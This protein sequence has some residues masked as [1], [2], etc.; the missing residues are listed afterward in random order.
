MRMFRIVLCALALT[1]CATLPLTDPVVKSDWD[2]TMVNA[3][4]NVDAGNYFAAQRLVDE[5]ARIH[6]DT[7][8]AREIGFWK[9]VFTLDPANEQGS[10]AGGIA[11]L[12]QYLAS[13]DSSARYR[14]E[15]LVLRRTA[16]VAQ[17]VSAAA[18]TTPSDTTAKDTVGVTTTTRSRDEE[19]VAL[20]DQLARTKDE[21][22]KVSAELDRIKKRLANPSN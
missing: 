13:S 11:G 19:I 17:G 9:A 16:A 22:A 20:K 8:E 6:P 10:L 21:L 7:P 15:A 1:G 2:R 5:F 3:R 14:N 4:R 18:G 12:D